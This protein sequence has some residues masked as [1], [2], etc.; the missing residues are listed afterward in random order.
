MGLSGFA[1]GTRNACA[2]EGARTRAAHRLKLFPIGRAQL[3]G[4]LRG[5]PQLRE[6]EVN[7]LLPRKQLVGVALTVRLLHPLL[8]VVGRAVE[9]GEGEEYARRIEVD[10][11]L[12]AAARRECEVIG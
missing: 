8:D 12:T 1:E 3:D 5:V 9:R 10:R 7:P 11:A 4:I 2:W 6:A